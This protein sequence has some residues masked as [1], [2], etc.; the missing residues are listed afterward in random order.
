MLESYKIIILKIN[1]SLRSISK[2]LK[3]ELIMTNIK[4]IKKYALLCLSILL[5]TGSLSAQTEENQEKTTFSDEPELNGTVMFD[6]GL[7]MLIDAPSA[8]GTK[9]L[10]SRSAGLYYMR[11]FPLG[12][13]LSFNPA[14]GFTVEKYSFDEHITLNYVDDGSGAG[15]TVLDIDTLGAIS[16]TKS[17]L[18]TTYL[19]APVE[20]RYFFKGNESND[21]AYL[22]LGG[23]VGFRLESH[24]KVKFEEEGIKK[25]TK[26]RDDYQQKNLR[27]G[28]HARVGFKGVNLFYKQSFSSIFG[29]EG[30]SGTVDTSYRTIGI[31]I[32]GL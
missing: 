15:T 24:T 17:A 19:E 21:G 4:M 31:S 3:S 27:Y 13:K 5:I 2:Y 10:Q 23:F 28:L 14:L 18:A 32:S 30:P 12:K 20:F 6:F 1:L 16:L 22:A 9:L 11:Q 7:N 29:S 8:M 25:L 26:K